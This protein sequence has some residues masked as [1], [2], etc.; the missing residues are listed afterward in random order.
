MHP[1][2]LLFLLLSFTFHTYAAPVGQGNK[3][4][5]MDIVKKYLDDFYSSDPVIIGQF[6]TKGS[7]PMTEKLKAMQRFFKL[8]V[9]GEADTET[10]E[11]MMKARC[12]VPDLGQFVL[13]D[14]NPKWKHTNITY[15]IV[16]Y[17][18]D[19]HHAEVDKAIQK[20][21]EV[22]SNV[23][24]LTFKKLETGTAD[25]IIS[26]ERRVHGDNSPFDGPDGILAHAFQP[27]PYIGGDA[28]FDEDELW[29]SQGGRGRNLFLVAAHELGHSLGLSHSTDSGA[30][31]YPTYSYTEP[32]A[33]KL[34]QDDINGIQAIYGKPDVAVQP[35][36]PTT[37]EACDPR[38]TF[39]AVTS[40]RGEIMFFK[41][42]HFW[43]KHPQLP[44]VELYF[45]SLFW[46]SLPATGIDA[47]YENFEEDLVFLFKGNKYWVLNGYEILSGYPRSIDRLGFPR[48][49]K[50]IDAAFSDPESGKTYFFV[51]SK[52]WR[53]DEITH[54][55]ERGYPK[56]IAR[57]FEGVGPQ[58]DAALY[59]DGSIYF[60]QGTKL[61]QFDHDSKSVAQKTQKSNSLLNC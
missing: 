5:D 30:L 52:Y 47:A 39:D 61:I 32:S 14:G 7:D 58:I 22:W 28:H 53:Y 35:T 60:F 27:G 17:T 16:N 3:D 13:T 37:P 25:I 59:H 48:T 49:V 51:G 11:V 40:L 23:S 19:M 10:L 50:K 44:D 6:K 1:P 18:P 36:G 41:G 57:N 55:M 24:P 43:R 34:P 31:M 38:T 15:S 12:G 4:G 21:F 42:R 29:T 46:P 8:K 20:A 26:F 33:F 56:S 2:I 54:S 9:T 45:I